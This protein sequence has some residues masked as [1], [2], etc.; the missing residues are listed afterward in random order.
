ME[1]Q[2]KHL[3]YLFT[4]QT[5]AEQ[6]EKI[7]KETNKQGFNRIDAPILTSFAKQY[8]EKKTLS[9]KQLEVLT[10]RLAKYRKQ[11]PPDNFTIG[12]ALID[13]EKKCKILD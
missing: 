13:Y 11:Q 3:L 12:H 2:I 4:L 1:D 7:V 5:E 8:L 10:K 6:R 9:A